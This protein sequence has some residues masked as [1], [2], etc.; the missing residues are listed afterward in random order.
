V[1]VLSL[2]LAACSRKQETRHSTPALPVPVLTARVEQKAAPRLIDAIG[3][4]QAYAT[5]S[6]K[7]QV[8]GQLAKAHFHEGQEVKPGDLL[9]TID[10]RPFEVA[11]QEAQAELDKAKA[12]AD[13]A[14][15]QAKR[16]TELNRRRAV[17]AEQFEASELARATS[18]AAL[19]SAEAAV[20]KAEL[21][22]EY[23]TIRSPIAGRTGNRLADPGN[24][25]SANATDLVVIN[26]IEPV[27][28]SCTVAERHLGE[29]QRYLATPEGVLARARYEGTTGTIAQGPVTFLNNA[30]KPG[31]G[32]IQLKA[33]LTNKDHALWPGQFVAVELILATQADAIL[34]PD[35]AISTGQNGQYVY[36]VAD[37]LSVQP[38]PVEVD[39][40][41]G[42]QMVI[43]EGL[44][45]GEQVV[46]DGQSRLL[47]GSKV[48]IRTSI[49]SEEPAAAPQGAETAGEADR[50]SAQGGR[51]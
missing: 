37:D 33:T 44:K 40:R 34:A 13:N 22:L 1:A 5:V 31:S 24:V 47:P 30:V 20:R 49:S 35:R 10:Q 17:A 15:R 43:R 18:A 28:I 9:F 2:A 51:S 11:L 32:T 38:R 27:Y 4:V 29:L 16:Y 7:P 46:I 48:E 12:N 45:A 8:T 26:Q 6:I 25:V 19:K 14:D 23:C 41:V 39:R 36:V 42:R 50:A 3:E 21:E